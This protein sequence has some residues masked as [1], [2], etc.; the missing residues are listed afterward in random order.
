MEIDK[1]GITQPGGGCW[2]RWPYVEI[3]NAAITHPMHWCFC[4]LRPR[5]LGWK[6]AQTFADGLRRIDAPELDFR[7]M[8]RRMDPRDGLPFSWSWICRLHSPLTGWLI[9]S[10]PEE[11][12][13]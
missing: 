9:R 10:P 3:D 13:E 1:T 12:N 5:G 8:P 4:Q 7:L 11:A 2:R 6:F